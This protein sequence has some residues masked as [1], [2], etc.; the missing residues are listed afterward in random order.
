[1]SPVAAV[2]LLTQW[3]LHTDH[4]SYTTP[5]SISG[6]LVISILAGIFPVLLLLS[7]RRKGDFVPARTLRF[8]GH[9][10]VAGSLY[11][12]FLGNLLLHGLWIWKHPI[13][14]A[15]AL[16]AAGLVVG[17]TVQIRRHGGFSPRAVLDL[18]VLPRCDDRAEFTLTA[19]GQPATAAACLRYTDTEPTPVSAPGEIQAFSQL[20]TATFQCPTAGATELRV[21]AHR[22]TDE[23]ELESLP[24]VLAVHSGG[25]V[26]RADAK[27]SGGPIDSPL[28]SEG[29]RVEIRVHEAP[30]P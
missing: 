19:A 29:C 7:S 21:W 14:R 10:L 9:P 16:L 20:H 11:L 2:F 24:V 12:L 26:T 28:H 27:L 22:M 1:V 25:R 8:L 18:L 23:G 15:C 17:V 30:T 13:E 5:L 4:A 3:L 6:V